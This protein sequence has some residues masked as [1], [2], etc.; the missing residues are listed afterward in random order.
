MQLE[1]KSITFPS[2]NLS[3][4]SLLK[5]DLFASSTS[6]SAKRSFLFVSSGSILALKTIAHKGCYQGL[7]II[8]LP[9]W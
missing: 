9:T 5:K 2:H 4:Q 1:W 7:I 3:G 6:E 8:Q